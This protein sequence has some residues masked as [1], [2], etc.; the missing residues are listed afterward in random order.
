MKRRGFLITLLV[1]VAAVAALSF[2]AMA[3]RADLRPSPGPVAGMVDTGMVYVTSTTDEFWHQVDPATFAK[4]GY[5]RND[6]KW[7][8]PSVIGKDG[9]V[10]GGLPGSIAPDTLPTPTYQAFV[11]L[12]MPTVNLAGLMSTG[13]VYVTQPS[14]DNYWH[15]V[16]AADFLTKGYSWYQ[17][18]W[19]GALPG[20]IVP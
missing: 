11:D 1:A 2:G 16:S 19:F 5:D 7:Y 10:A 15:P 17:V 4:L 8:G 14:V 12:F 3:A 13:G 18:K 9:A 6:I 20:S